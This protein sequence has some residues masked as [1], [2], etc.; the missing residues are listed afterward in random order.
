MTLPLKEYNLYRAQYLICLIHIWYSRCPKHESM[1]C[2]L[3]LGS[4]SF[5]IFCWT[6]NFEPVLLAWAIRLCTHFVGFWV[7]SYTMILHKRLGNWCHIIDGYPIFEP[8]VI[9]QNSKWDHAKI[10]TFPGPVHGEV[11]VSIT[12]CGAKLLIYSQ[13][14]TVQPLKLGNR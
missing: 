1:P 9:F 7:V 4:G 5:S 14:S 12:K 11:I 10:E 6:L 3:E 2:Y 8:N 13:I